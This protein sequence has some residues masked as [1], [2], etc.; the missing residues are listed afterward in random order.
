MIRTASV[1][2]LLALAS[3]ETVPKKTYANG[4]TAALG[5]IANLEGVTVE[6]LEVIEDS[7]CPASVQC[8]WAGR[9]RISAEVSGSGVLELTLGE[10]GGGQWRHAEHVDVRRERDDRR[11]S[12]ADYQFTFAQRPRPAPSP[13]TLIN[14]VDRRAERAWILVAHRMEQ[15]GQ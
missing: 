8:V 2:A 6:P 12:A 11:Y 13:S 3:C 14:L 4:P 1:L 9:V 7:R 10:A 15:I 5:E